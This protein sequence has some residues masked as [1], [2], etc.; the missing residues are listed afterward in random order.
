[1]ERATPT[2]VRIDCE[3][4]SPSELSGSRPTSVKDD[5]RAGSVRPELDFDN[6]NRAIAADDTAVESTMNRQHHTGNERGS[7]TQVSPNH[8]GNESRGETGESK[9]VT[10]AQLRRD[11]AAANAADS[12]VVATCS[13]SVMGR[14]D[15]DDDYDDGDDADDDERDVTTALLSQ[16]LDEKPAVRVTVPAPDLLSSPSSRS[17]PKRISDSGL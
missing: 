17:R 3:D 15:V 14:R 12:S 5:G 2:Y 10:A 16:P 8:V 11:F 4:G 13:T 9:G 1:M 6:W 7:A